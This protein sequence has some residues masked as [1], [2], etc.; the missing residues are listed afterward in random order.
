M[1]LASTSTWPRAVLP[2][3]TTVPVGLL[4]LVVGFGLGAV[5]GLVVGWVVGCAD[6]RAVALGVVGAVDA[7]VPDAPQAAR[8]TVARTAPRARNCWADRMST[9]LLHLSETLRSVSAQAS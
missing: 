9:E 4:G 5:V 7:P 3:F 6:G 2:R 8:T 1:P